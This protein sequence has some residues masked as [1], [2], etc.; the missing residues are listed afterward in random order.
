[1]THCEVIIGIDLKNP[2]TAAKRFWDFEVTQE[3]LPKLRNLSDLYWGYWLW[4]SYLA[5]TRVDNI[6][7]YIVFGVQNKETVQIVARALR[8]RGQETLE[9]WPG[10]YF[11][12]EST[13][14][15]ALLGEFTDH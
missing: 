6:N 15:L 2:V 10:Q 9:D 13:E 11:T 1:M 7:K 4:Y 3:K 8:N 5:G 12:V 14:G